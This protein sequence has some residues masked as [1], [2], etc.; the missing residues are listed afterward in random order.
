MVLKCVA[1]D[2]E[3]GKKDYSWPESPGI[4]F[5]R[6]ECG[7]NKVTGACRL[8][9]GDDSTA[10]VPFGELPQAGGKNRKSC[11]TRGHAYPQQQPCSV[12][13]DSSPWW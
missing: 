2:G 3:E 4:S 9:S 12:A 5:V 11:T 6:N 8:T 1:D 13:G 7:C 10:R